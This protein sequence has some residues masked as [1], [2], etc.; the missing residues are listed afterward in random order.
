MTINKQFAF[1]SIILPTYNRGSYISNVI[2][3]ICSQ[4]YKNWELIIV[5][6]GSIDNTFSL[7]NNYEDDSRIKFLKKE[8]S[9]AADSRNYGVKFAKYD[10]LIFVDS[11]DEVCED[12][13]SKMTESINDDSE[14]CLVSCGNYITY[15][16]ELLSTNL[17]SPHFIYKNYDV[18]FIAGAFLLKKNIFNAVG[19]YDTEFKANQHLD[20]GVRVLKYINDNNLLVKK[21]D[22]PL[23]NIIKRNISGIR[24]NHYNVL[25]STILFLNKYS[26]LL[27]SSPQT[28]YTYNLICSYRSRKMGYLIKS[29][30]FASIAIA[31]NPKKLKGYKYLLAAIFVPRNI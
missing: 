20:L 29:I 7:L 2:E 8:N 17:P 27:R 30:K 14:L 10:Y 9:G 28:V 24:N 26:S 3:N 19:G 16:N 22:F 11:D 25:S 23:V 15:H 18:N 31:Q 12:W 1:I 6:D 5:D 21:I 13:L 4:K